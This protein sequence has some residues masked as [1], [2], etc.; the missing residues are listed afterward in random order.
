MEDITR[1]PQWSFAVS[2]YQLT[3]NTSTV[4]MSWIVMGVL[5][6]FGLLATRKARLVPGPVQSVAEVVVQAFRN[7]VRE[8]LGV[9][10]DRYFA[11]ILTLFVF[12]LLSNW[13][14][15]IPF[16]EEPTKDLNTTLILGIVGFVVAHVSAIRVKGWKA[17]V[18][19]YF[20]PFFLML[21]L[22]V[23]GELAKV[24][25]IS[26]RLYGNIMGGAIILVVVSRL[27]RHLILP[28]FLQVFFGVFVGTVQAFVF[29]ML[30]L[31][32]ISVAVQE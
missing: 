4:V 28:P 9:L 21:P 13:I 10:G 19:A 29:A 18:G 30:T 1:I 27:V 23:I 8:T 26:F 14:G 3:V 16:L 6:A 7:L 32:Y 25:S 15:M 11:L 2:G 5:I 31:T 12:I 24:V 17:Y 20:E 22:N